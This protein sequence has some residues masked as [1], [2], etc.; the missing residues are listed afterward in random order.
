VVVD[1]HHAAEIR[2]LGPASRALMTT[3]AGPA[4]AAGEGWGIWD[5]AAVDAPPA[6]KAPPWRLPSTAGRAR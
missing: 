2:G 5:L 6:V 4:S 3:L 1:A